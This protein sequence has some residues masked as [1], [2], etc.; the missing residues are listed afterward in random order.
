MLNLANVQYGG[1]YLIMDD[2]KGMLLGAVIERCAPRNFHE[3]KTEIIL[4]HEEQQFNDHLLRMFNFTSDQMAIVND[5]HVRDC[6]PEVLEAVQW[7]PAHTDPEKLRMYADK[8]EERRLNF[9]Q[10]QELRLKT[11][12]SLDRKDFMAILLAI[13]PGVYTAE[14]LVDTWTPFLQPGGFMV[15]YSSSKEALNSAFFE[16]LVSDKFT[17]VRITESFLRPY[18]TAEGRLHPMMNCNGHGGFLLSMIRTA[19]CSS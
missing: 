8:I 2:S 14:S 9:V 18:Q 13:E 16:A 19:P 7:V 3:Q 1:K 17:D 5:L 10:K 15:I 6:L 4:I 12:K 11:R